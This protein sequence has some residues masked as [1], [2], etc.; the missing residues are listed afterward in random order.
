[1]GAPAILIEGHRHGDVLFIPV[2]L[3]ARQYGAYVSSSCTSGNCA[4]IWPRDILVYMRVKGH[5]HAPGLLEA[6]PK[7][8]SRAST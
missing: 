1:M 4:A 3:F 2:K 5:M 6:Y 7:G 8:A